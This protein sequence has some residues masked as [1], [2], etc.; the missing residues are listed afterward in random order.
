MLA[1]IEPPFGNS[2]ARV[3]Q[4]MYNLRAQLDEEGDAEEDALSPLGFCVALAERKGFRLS[5]GRGAAD[6]H[7]AGLEVLR[8]CVD[9]AV[10][11]AFSPPDSDSSFFWTSSP[12]NRNWPSSARS[13]L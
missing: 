11:L 7:R 13:S 10:C 1:M 3:A 9:G 2:R 12:L 5:R 4:R 6:A 8:D